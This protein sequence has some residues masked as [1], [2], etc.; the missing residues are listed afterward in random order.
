MANPMDSPWYS[1]GL[2]FR[3]TQCGD[4]CT[5]EPGYVWVNDVEIDAIAEA[6]GESREVFLALRTKISGRGR[7]LR[8]KLDGDCI[9]YEKG[10]GCTIYAVRPMQC[11][12]WPF[13]ESNVKTPKHWEKTCDICPGSGT[14]DLISADEITQRMRAVR[15]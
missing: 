9:Y 8:E 11:R 3:C 10:R 5:G 7:S 13:W 15:L 12:T 14:G 4:Y 2:R 1:S 6:V